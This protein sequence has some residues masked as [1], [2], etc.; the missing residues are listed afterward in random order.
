MRRRSAA[1]FLLLILVL[2]ACLPLAGCS[3]EPVYYSEEEIVSYIRSVYGP[4]YRLTQ[5][6]SY[7]DDTEEK[8]L[9][10]V[11]QFEN[12]EGMSFSVSTYSYHIGIDATTTAFYSKG[13]TDDYAQRRIAFKEAEIRAVLEGSPFVWDFS[14]ANSGIDLGVEDYLQLP[15]AAQLVAELDRAVD[16]EGDFHDTTYTSNDAWVY[17][18]LKPTPGMED[19]DSEG[20]SWQ[21]NYR[22]RLMAVSLTRGGE[23]QRLDGEDLAWRLQWNLADEVKTGR[24]PYYDLPDQFL[25]QYP[26]GYLRVEGL[27]P[28]PEHQYGFRFDLNSRK[29]WISSLDPCQDY[30]EFPYNYSD[31]GAFAA[32]VEALGGSYQCTEDGAEWTIGEDTWTATLLLDQE[33][34]F[35]NLLV[36]RNGQTLILD[37]PDGRNNGTVSGRAF[38]LEDLEQLLGVTVEVDQYS[39]TARLLLE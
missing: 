30:E 12:S 18:Y 32:L 31:R 20:E 1:R 6:S 17:L 5:R 16:M 10:Y 19:P 7:E 33:H 22:Y 35:Q 27:A 13:I 24:M 25:Y 9:V 26:A 36:T 3:T 8:N 39:A 14:Q 23:E 4:D 21:S 29:Y 2:L 28:E 38:T 11:Y 15:Q 34:N 37:E